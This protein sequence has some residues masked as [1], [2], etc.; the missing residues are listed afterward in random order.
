MARIKNFPNGWA[1]YCHAC[2]SLH[3]LDTRFIFNYDMK[4][5]TFKDQINLT[6]TLPPGHPQAGQ[7]VQCH[8]TVTK[9]VITYLGTSTHAFKGQQLGLID[10]EE[11]AALRRAQ[12]ESKRSLAARVD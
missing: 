10:F 6:V 2:R 5:P 1:F 4:L 12:E 7:V 8:S 3:R 9:G 11:M